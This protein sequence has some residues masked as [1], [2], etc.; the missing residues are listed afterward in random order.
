MTAGARNARRYTHAEVAAFDGRNGSRPVL[1]AYEGRVYDVSDSFPWR[2][3]FHWGCAYGGQELTG[4]L[5]LAPHGPE[6]LERVPCVGI[7]A[8]EN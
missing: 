4:M 2:F 8:D 1:I 5:E 7:L 6:L 3:G